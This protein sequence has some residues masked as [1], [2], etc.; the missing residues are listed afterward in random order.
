LASK[1]INYNYIGELCLSRNEL[2]AVSKGIQTVSK[3]AARSVLVVSWLTHVDLCN[4]HKMVLIVLEFS[5]TCF[6]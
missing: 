5:G 2:V 4:V 6:A 1:F 3:T